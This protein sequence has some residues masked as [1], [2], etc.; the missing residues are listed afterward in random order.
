MQ[1]ILRMY[2]YDKEIHSI[3]TETEYECNVYQLINNLRLHSLKCQ[4]KHTSGEE[5]EKDNFS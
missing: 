3:F 4:M 1:R 5:N 2:K